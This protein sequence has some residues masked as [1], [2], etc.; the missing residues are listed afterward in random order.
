MRIRLLAA[1]LA[2]QFTVLAAGQRGPAQDQEA[3]AIRNANEVYMSPDTGR[4]KGAFYSPANLYTE[5]GKGGLRIIP[6]EQFL[7]NLAKGE[8]SGQSRPTMTI[9]FID[10]AGSAATV[11]VTEI[12]DVA[13][14]TDYFSLV[15][16]ATGWKIV[17]KTFNVEHK[18]EANSSS[19]SSMQASAATLCPSDELQALKFLAGNWSTAESPVSSGGAI[20]GTSRTETILNGCALWEHRLVEQKGK[21]LFDAHIILGYDV[22]TKKMFLFYV[23]DGSHTQVYEGRREGGS[24]AF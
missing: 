12:S 15:R 7:A 24:W 17:S 8:A 13:R 9:D 1:L 16:D 6:L 23:D 20:T 18:A 11:R 14:V 2:T 4:V 19:Q 3:V 22:T 10:H 21:E 5:D